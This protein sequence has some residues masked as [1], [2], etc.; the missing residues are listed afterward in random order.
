MQRGLRIN[1]DARK[2]WLQYFRLEFYYVEKIMGRRELLGLE[3]DGDGGEVSTERDGGDAVVGSTREGP[4]ESEA[5]DIPQLEG[6]GEGNDAA[7]RRPSFKGVR[8]A[9]SAEREE[10]AQTAGSVMNDTVRRFY[11]G[12]VPLAVYRAA[13]KAVPDDVEFRAGFL[14]C[15]ALDFPALG[16][17]VAQAI[18]TSIAEDFSENCD[19]WEL[20]ASYPLLVA[21]GSGEAGGEAGEGV[22]GEGEGKGVT[23]APSHS[24]SAF[25][26]SVKIFERAVEEIGNRGPEIWMRYAMFLQRMVV[27]SGEGRRR[28][29]SDARSKAALRTETRE[30]VQLM[31]EVLMKA[32]EMHVDKNHKNFVVAAAVGG[33]VE[34]AVSEA[35]AAERR[36]IATG[37]EA[38]PEEMD[39]IRAD[40]Q[41]ALGVGLADVSLMLDE[42]EAALAALRATANCLPTRPGPWLR[43]SSLER[44]AKTLRGEA[45]EDNL[46]KVAETASRDTS[47]QEE[48]TPTAQSD[49]QMIIGCKKGTRRGKARD[50]SV[51][52]LRRALKAV[53]A[54]DLGYP[55][56]WRELLGSLVAGGAGKKAITAA[57]RGAIEGCNPSGADPGD[58]QGEFLTGYIRWSAAVEGAEGARSALQW[59]RRSF[60]LSG[61]GAAPAYLA[62]IELERMLGEEGGGGVAGGARTGAGRQA[63]G[64]S[65]R[66]R[67]LFEVRAFMT[68]GAVRQHEL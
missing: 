17:E 31:Q 1:P 59:A 28:R 24:G 64:R 22:G 49:G 26:E 5:M 58:A 67:E 54:T 35:A 48:I 25:G 14:R 6:E 3:G 43:L 47:R 12:A 18:L 30:L 45:M 40:A 11:R 66:V 60:L 65:K 41:E 23:S 61:A 53:P 68:W 39:K 63:E 50:Q 10:A 33:G 8:K 4:R 44:R 38:D 19:A 56:L 62:A 7:E 2:L 37:K 21:E 55:T 57:F 16:A 27:A 42:P 15:C 13:V 20:R 46:G 29:K 36:K 32:V 9:A 34:A 51:D 52:T